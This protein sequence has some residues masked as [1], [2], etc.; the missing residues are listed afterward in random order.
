MHAVC[1]E[2]IVLA[3]EATLSRSLASSTGAG[4]QARY[5][6]RSMESTIKESEKGMGINPGGGNV[7]IV[8]S[9][10]ASKDEINCALHGTN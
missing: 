9:L 8:E 2:E 10:G 4:D 1:V 5:T 7:V 6:A 3:S